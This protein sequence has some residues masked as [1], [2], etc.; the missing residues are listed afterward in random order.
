MKSLRPTA[1][2]LGVAAVLVLPAPRVFAST[3][4]AWDAYTQEVTAACEAASGLKGARPAGDL[5]EFDDRVG[6][7]VL[8]IAGRY[9]Q[10]HMHNARARIL[11]L[12]DRRSRQ[13]SVADAEHIS[14]RTPPPPP[15]A[16]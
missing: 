1:V 13:A 15:V 10:P 16:Q 6:I 9:P 2:L 4:E 14:R 5:I 11:C 3:P 8:L 12:F 7:T